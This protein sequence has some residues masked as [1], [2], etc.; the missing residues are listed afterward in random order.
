MSWVFE[1]S[2]ELFYLFA[3]ITGMAGTI[4]FMIWLKI[5]P[6]IPTDFYTTEKAHEK[7][8][9]HKGLDQKFETINLEFKH[10]K[11]QNKNLKDTMLGYNKNINDQI[12]G[13]RNAI[14][15]VMNNKHRE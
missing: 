13:L 12:T 5:Q 15:N 7:F 11:E 14:Q 10:I 2:K 4:W 3:L 6:I 9:S 8:V 1:N